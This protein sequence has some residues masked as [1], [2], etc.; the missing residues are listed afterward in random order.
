MSR[1]GFFLLA[2]MLAVPSLAQ[3]SPTT[4]D[5]APRAGLTATV[6][7]SL[8]SQILTLEEVLSG[9]WPRIL[10]CRARCIPSALSNT[11]SPRRRALLIR[12]CLSGGM[13]ISPH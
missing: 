7:Q 13:G 11:K 9:H 12:W 1:L 6:D 4:Q 5:L 3:E 2:S 8:S 10:R